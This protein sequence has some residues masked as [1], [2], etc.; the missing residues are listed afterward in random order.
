[1]KLLF[2]LLPALLAV[3]LLAADDVKS[4]VAQKIAADYPSLDALYQDLHA[5]PELSLM[6]E[7]TAGIVARE[8]RDAGYDVTEKIGGHGTV[9]V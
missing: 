3:P 8:L 4:F 9:A 6:E 7:R 2:R 1:M 5:H